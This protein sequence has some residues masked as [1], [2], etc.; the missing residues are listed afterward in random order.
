[1]PGTLWYYY[2][3][4]TL[5]VELF[6]CMPFR[7]IHAVVWNLTQV[8]YL[9][10][11]SSLFVKC[12]LHFVITLGRVCLHKTSRQRIVDSHLQ[13]SE[14]NI[15]QSMH[16]TMTVCFNLAFVIYGNIPN[17]PI[18]IFT[19]TKNCKVAFH[20]LVKC[21][22][23]FPNPQVHLIN[24]KSTKKWIA[25]KNSMLSTAKWLPVVMYCDCDSFNLYL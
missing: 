16:V 24:R 2:S 14:C 23:L 4:T 7:V 15:C 13:F 12:L 9:V 18:W 22:L 8:L 10:V 17:A 19:T 6:C 25:W 11:S 3:L 5:M 21:T 1:M 20:H